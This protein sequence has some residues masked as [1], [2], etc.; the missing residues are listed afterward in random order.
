MEFT[1]FNE[2]ISVLGTFDTIGFDRHS[3]TLVIKFFDGSL[4][5]FKNVKESTVFK[6]VISENKQHYYENVFLPD[7][8]AKEPCRTQESSAR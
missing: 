3:E 8:T 1:T 7:Y 6:L 2:K 5:T 4:R